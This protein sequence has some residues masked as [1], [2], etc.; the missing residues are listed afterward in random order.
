MKTKRQAYSVKRIEKCKKILC[1]LFAVRDSLNASSRGFTLI[2]A[3][4]I[5]SIVLALGVSIFEIALKQVNLSSIGRESQFAFYSADTGAEC[6]LYWDLRSDIHPNT[7][8]TSSP[9]NSAANVICSQITA[10]ITTSATNNSVTSVF[11][12]EPD[13]KCAQVSV[14]KCSSNGVCD[15]NN[16]EV[17]TIVHSDGFNTSCTALSTSPR[18]LQRSVE[19][20]Y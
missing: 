2:L 1:S 11:Q 20:R 19:L 7:F 4:L 15:T 5:A 17:R 16:P 6:A 9:P 13:G 18:A 10:A 12:F 14:K 3:S 8:A